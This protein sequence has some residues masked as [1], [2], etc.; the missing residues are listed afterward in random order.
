MKFLILLTLTSLS[1]NHA[2]ARL[3]TLSNHCLDQIKELPNSPVGESHHTK[4]IQ[5]RAFFNLENNKMEFQ[6]TRC[7]LTRT[8]TLQSGDASDD[9]VVITFTAG[10]QLKDHSVQSFKEIEEKYCSKNLTYTKIS[11]ERRDYNKLKKAAQTKYCQKLNEKEFISK[12]FGYRNQ[13]DYRHPFFNHYFNIPMEQGSIYSFYLQQRNDEIAHFQNGYENDDA[14]ERS[15]LHFHIEDKAMEYLETS[16]FSKLHNSIALAPVQTHS[17]KLGK[18]Q[19]S[20]LIKSKIKYDIQSFTKE[21]LREVL[22]NLLLSQSVEKPSVLFFGRRLPYEKEDILL[23]L[24][25]LIN[26]EIAH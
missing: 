12:R 8:I 15:I 1:F 19:D 3:N 26:S 14:Y 10:P 6:G 22:E 24:S 23:L 17:W 11:I 9:Y 21:E 2:H 20:D 7:Q 5:T 25:K 13:N 18:D 4:E 16:R